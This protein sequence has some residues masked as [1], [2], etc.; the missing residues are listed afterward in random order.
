MGINAT[1]V[2]DVRKHSTIVLR[3]L[4]SSPKQRHEILD[5]VA[6]FSQH[7]ESLRGVATSATEVCALWGGPP[8]VTYNL[9]ASRFRVMVI[10]DEGATDLNV[11]YDVYH[12]LVRLQSVVASSADGLAN[13]DSAAVTTVYEEAGHALLA[14]DRFIV[15]KS[16]PSSTKPKW[17]PPALNRSS[18]L[19]D[20]RKK[21]SSLFSR[22][23]AAL[24]STST[25]GVFNA[26]SPREHRHAPDDTISTSENNSQ[27]F[28]SSTPL[29][30]TEGPLALPEA[31]FSWCY[32]GEPLLDGSGSLDWFAHLFQPARF[33]AP[34]ASLGKQQSQFPVLRSESTSTPLIVPTLDHTSVQ[35]SILESNHVA[36]EQTNTTE[37]SSLNN[38]ISEGGL[39]QTYSA[40]STSSQDSPAIASGLNP[41]SSQPLGVPP[42]QEKLERRPLMPE[43]SEQTTSNTASVQP[44][45]EFGK[46]ISEQEQLA[47]RKQFQD[48]KLQQQ[49]AFTQSQLQSHL[50]QQTRQ[51][52]FQQANLQIGQ[53]QQQVQLD[54]ISMQQQINQDNQP[55]QL[56]NDLSQSGPLEVDNTVAQPALESKADEKSDIP[57]ALIVK[58]EFDVSQLGDYKDSAST[59]VHVGSLGG[60]VFSDRNKSEDDAIRARMN[61][62][63]LTMQSGNFTVALRQVND[64]LRFLSN[65][66]PR[67]DREIVTC[68]NYI[69]AQKILIRNTMLEN[70]ITRFPMGGPEVVQRQVECALLTM[71]LAELKHLLPRHRV[72]AMRVAVEKNFIV[73]NFGMCA[74]WLRQLVEKAPPNQKMTIMNQLQTCLANAERNAHMPPTNRLCFETLQIVT[75]P[76]GKCDVCA[77]VY[78]ATLSGVIDRQVCDTCFVGT[79]YATK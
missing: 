45:Q 41:V 37:P 53:Q 57:D 3:T 38:H 11:A 49:Q 76:Y 42:T 46:Q 68:S 31:I 64:T 2:Y 29:D 32:F 65:L 51:H 78:H 5:T 6:S 73:G 20:P 52:E 26:K 33:V 4:S 34:V 63:A 72:A 14:D 18:N 35:S 66:E 70:E 25:S 30:D 44:H 9:S 1:I 74:R 79:I 59:S 55:G 39:K 56:R 60:P 69:L 19:S 75:S 21:K 43:K 47:E 28:G 61:K 23:G 16:M 71:F 54:N 24:K 8:F 36:S 15:S 13:G 10:W 27:V 58:D 17:L 50:K 22:L 77:A 67:R 48:Y 40:Q 12:A 7:C 62:F